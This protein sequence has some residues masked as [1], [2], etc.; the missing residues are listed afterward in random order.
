MLACSRAKRR[1]C[2]QS[3]RSAMSS[4]E[5]RWPRKR[6]SS[7]APSRPSATTLANSSA[8][9]L[10]GTVAIAASLTRLVV[11]LRVLWGDKPSWRG[12]C[13]TSQN[14]CV[15]VG[16][17]FGGERPSCECLTTTHCGSITKSLNLQSQH[18]ENN[19]DRNTTAYVVADADFLI[20]HNLENCVAAEP[21]CLDG[22]T[23][24]LKALRKFMASVGALDGV[25]E[26]LAARPAMGV[27]AGAGGVGLPGSIMATTV[28]R[29]D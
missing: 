8:L 29:D 27:G 7:S 10:V 22:S 14:D 23:A 20:Y 25:R 24:E 26:Y 19:A 4:P 15:C 18:G 13:C 11:L 28:D 6:P 5:R 1:S 3:I 9:P 16:P 2:R 17:F 12:D 21:T